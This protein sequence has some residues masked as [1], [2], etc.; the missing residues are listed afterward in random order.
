MIPRS[1]GRISKRQGEKA[2]LD[3]PGN[4]QNPWYQVFNDDVCVRIVQGF[5]EGLLKWVRIPF[6]D[7]RV[8]QMQADGELLAAARAFIVESDGEVSATAVAQDFLLKL[9]CKYTNK[10]VINTW[11]FLMHPIQMSGVTGTLPLAACRSFQSLR[12]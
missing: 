12:S 9:I 6:E 7:Y 8:P 3:S 1:N 4:P 10:T 11:P 5:I 2:E